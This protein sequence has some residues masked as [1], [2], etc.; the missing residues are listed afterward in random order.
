MKKWKKLA[1]GLPILLTAGFFLF[2]V[3]GQMSAASSKS[4][5]RSGPK[6]QHLKEAESRIYKLTN[7]ARQKNG[8]LSLDKDETLATVA[9][10]H[11]DDMLQR[12]FFSHTDPDGH[13]PLDRVAPVYSSTFSRTGENIW[14]GSG[15]DFSDQKL[16]A[17]IIVDGWMSS[18]KHRENILNPNYTNLG[19]GVAVMG[20]EI[21]ATQVF[22][23]RK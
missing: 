17:R 20:K 7:E 19:V 2:Q 5:G 18:P 21:R 13:S 16:L 9:R 8:L 22:V 1:A 15:H 12:Q 4:P 10:A 3:V 14:G 6:I 11:S 23:R